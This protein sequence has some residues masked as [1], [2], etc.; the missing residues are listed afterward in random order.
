MDTAH[1]PT[2]EIPTVFH[3][4]SLDPARKNLRSYEGAGLSISLDPNEWSAIARL[5]S[6]VW[7]LERPG[8][9]FLDALALHPS[10]RGAIEQ[11]G[12]D[13]GWVD[14]VPAWRLTYFD[15]ELG[16]DVYSLYADHATALTEAT[17]LDGTTPTV[18]EL[19]SAL[20]AT[21]AFDDLTVTAG[22][23]VIENP[24]I[25]AWV[26]R[27][28][29]ELEGVWW[30]YDRRPEVLSCPCGVI[31]VTRLAHWTAAETTLADASLLAV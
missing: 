5:G 24:L 1:L 14:R 23:L 13:L 17:A 20:V 10:Q 27:C 6:R 28:V 18:V 8:A 19:T 30:E 26:E 25:A 7:R 9:R 15:E 12:L 29:P 21:D 2:R 11:W 3:V 31:G 22:D 4:G 16:E